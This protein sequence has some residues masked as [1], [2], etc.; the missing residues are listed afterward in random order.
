MTKMGHNRQRWNQKEVQQQKERYPVDVMSDEEGLNRDD[1]DVKQKIWQARQ[2]K[3]V[4][5]E[6]QAGEDGEGE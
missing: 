5:L 3:K 6:K 2:I 1:P 4:W